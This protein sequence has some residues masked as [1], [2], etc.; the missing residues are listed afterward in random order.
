MADNKNQAIREIPKHDVHVEAS[1]ENRNVFRELRKSAM[2]EYIIPKSTEVMR[3]FMTG[4]VDMFAS[5]LRGSIDKFLYPDG[6]VPKKTTQSNG[7]YTSTTNYTSFSRPIGQYQTSQQRG[8]DLIGQRPGNQVKYVW[9]KTEEDAK[10]VVGTLKEDID[11]YGKVKV[12]VFYE[13]IGERT[14]MADFTYGWT[15][16][17]QI[18]YFYD[19][20]RPAGENKWFIDLPKPVDI[21]NI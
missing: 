8:R 7:Y 5:A 4:M 20:S 11:N 6:N 3:D 13:M 21:T 9:L 18:G 10:R 12:A 17:D 16:S 19:T 14:T 2:E 15:Q 1:I